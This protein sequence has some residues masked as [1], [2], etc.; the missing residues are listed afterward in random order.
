MWLYL[1]ESEKF[2]DFGNESALVWHETSIPYAVWGTESTRSVSLKY[3]PSQVSLTRSIIFYFE[4][5]PNDLTFFFYNS[6]SQQVVMLGGTKIT[7][8]LLGFKEQWESLCSRFLC[9]LWLPSRPKWSRIPASFCV[10]KDI[11]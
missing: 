6:F 8:C 10:W 11:S 3:Y 2:N 4:N 9:T 5:T 7:F 1:S